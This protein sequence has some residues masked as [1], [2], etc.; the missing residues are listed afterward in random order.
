MVLLTEKYGLPKRIKLEEI[1]PNTIAIIKLIKSRII[2][3]DAKKIIEIADVIKEVDPNKKVALV[4]TENICS[5]SKV[6]LTSADV[7]II[8][9]E[10]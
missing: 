3:K 10:L 7:T 2:Q 1:K 5:K 8:F 4:C 6:L 9:R